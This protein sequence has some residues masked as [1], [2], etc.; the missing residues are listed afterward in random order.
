MCSNMCASPVL[1]MGSCTD[2]ASTC[3]KKENTGASG[4]SQMMTVSPLASVF[5]V[6]RFSKEARSWPRT[7][8]HRTKQTTIVCIEIKRDFILP[9]R[10]KIKK[11]EVTWSQGRL[12][13]EPSVERRAPSPVR[14]VTADSRT[15]LSLP[16]R[17]SALP[18]PSGV[19]RNHGLSRLAAKSL[20]EG[21][22]ILHRAIH[23]PASRRMRIDQYQLPR[24]LLRHV[25]A[26][27]LPIRKKVP[28][29]GRISID[30]LHRCI[31]NNGQQCHIRQLQSSVVGRIFTQR[32]LAI[33]LNVALVVLHRN[34]TR[35]LVGRAIGA[36]LKFLGVLRRPPV[37]EIALRIVLP[38]LVVEAV[39]EFMSNHHPDAAIIHRVI[40]QLAVKRRLQNSRGKV[41][42]I[43]RRPVISVNRWWSHPPILTIRRLIDLLIQPLHLERAR[44]HRIARIIAGRNHHAAVIAPSVG[45]ANIVDDGGELLISLFL[46]RVR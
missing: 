19:L 6:I 10:N 3:V 13:N 36:L 45:I 44:A 32:Q 25:L 39:R 28:L 2:P 41:D 35:I 26:P 11:F 46:S 9:P 14:V 21:G 1:F 30:R 24:L 34:K 37:A 22:R 27:D 29:R 12:S 18:E 16:S 17:S 8:E 20:L 40:H 7:S 38:A 15:R 43:H 31:A 5:T 23:P 42:I 4:R 33:E